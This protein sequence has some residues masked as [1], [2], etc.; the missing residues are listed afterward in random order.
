MVSSNSSSY[1]THLSFPHQRQFMVFHWNLSDRKSTQVFRTLLSILADLNKALVWIVSTRPLI[2]KSSCPCT[3]PLVI[4]PSAP[5][6]IG[7]TITSMFHGFSVLLQRLGTYLSFRFPSV[8]PFGQPPLYRFFFFFF[9]FFVN[10][11]QVRSSGR[12]QRISFYH[13]ILAKFLRLIFQDGFQVVH[14]PFL[15]MVKSKLLAQFP[16][17]LAHLG[18]SCL[19]VSLR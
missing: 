7:I 19:I 8:L 5:I 18:V 11:H 13:K 10:Y 15:G 16:V 4:I 12:D 14:I 2:S 9:F 1:F 3:K 6:T 17:D